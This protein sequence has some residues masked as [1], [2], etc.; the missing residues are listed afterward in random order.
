MGVSLQKVDAKHVVRK[1]SHRTITHLGSKG[2][3][4]THADSLEAHFCT[5]LTYVSLTPD[6]FVCNH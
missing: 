4:S 2:M 1:L 3:S 5:Q 6:S